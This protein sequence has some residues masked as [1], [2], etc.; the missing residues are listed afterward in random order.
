MK[1]SYRKSNNPTKKRAFTMIELIAGLLAVTILGTATAIVAQAV[2][3]RSRDQVAVSRLTSLA[4][5]VQVKYTQAQGTQTWEQVLISAAEEV[6]FTQ[7]SSGLSA[8]EGVIP[9]TFLDTCNFDGTGCME[10]QVTSLAPDEV[11][12]K[13]AVVTTGEYANQSLVGLALKSESGN[14]VMLR[15][16]VNSILDAWSTGRD[17]A[18]DCRGA[19]ALGGP[20]AEASISPTS[21]AEIGIPAQITNLAANGTGINE[22]VLSWTPSVSTDVTQYKIVR[23]GG[24]SIDPIMVSS[25]TVCTL[26]GC[27]YND[28]TAKNG[29]SYSYQVL[30]VDNTGY[31]GRSATVAVVTVPAGPTALTATGGISK[32]T[33]SWTEGSNSLITGYNIYLNG[34]TTPTTTAPG[35]VSTVILRDG[36]GGLTVTNGET[37]SVILKAYNAGGESVEATAT[38]TPLDVPAAPE[39]TSSQV[40]N[41]AVTLNWNTVSPTQS[42]PISGYRVYVNGSYLPYGKTTASATSTITGLTNGQEYA[43]QVAS[44]GT[45]G[46]GSASAAFNSTPVAPPA[47]PSNARITSITG[48]TVQVQWDSEATV[49][50]PVDNYQIY[51][52][53]EKI[54]EIGSNQLS[55]TV[56]GLTAGTGAV[57]KVRAK[58]VGPVLGA[59][60]DELTITSYNLPAVPA[61]VTV[62]Q[63]AEGELTL[64]WSA[65]TSTNSTPVSGYRIYQNGSGIP[66]TTGAS[67]KKFSSLELG[68][69]HSFQVAAYNLSGQG[70]LSAAEGSRAIGEPAS[71][72]ITFNTRTSGSVE[73]DIEVPNSTERPV[74]SVVLQR[75]LANG[76]NCQP[77]TAGLTKN[78][79]TVLGYGDGGTSYTFKLEST[80]VLNTATASTVQTI[81][82]SAIAPSN[83]TVTQ[84]AEGELTLAWN[85]VNA[86]ATG[87]ITNYQVYLNDSALLGG[88][89]TETSKTFTN[90]TL[91]TGYDLAVSARTILG[92]GASSANI[93]KTAIGVPAA[94]TLNNAVYGDGEITYS[95]AVPTSS[96]RPVDDVLL[97]RCAADGTA[98]TNHLTNLTTASTSAKVTGTG[99][100]TYTYKLKSTNVVGSTDVTD[101]RT[102][103]S[104]ASAP[105][106]VSVTRTDEKLTLDWN[107]VTDGGAGDVTDYQI[108]ISSNGGAFSTLLGGTSTGTSKEYTLGAS[109]LTLGN[110]YSFMVAARSAAGTG[111]FSAATSAVVA[112]GKPATP[113]IARKVSGGYGDGTVIFDIT[114][115]TSS[116]RPVSDVKLQ[117]CNSAGNACIDQVTTLTSSSTTVTGSGTGG[118]SYLFKLVSTNNVGLESAASVETVYNVAPAPT[119]VVVSQTGANELTLTWAAVNDASVGTVSDYQLRLSEN[120][121]AMSTLLGGTSS[122]TTKIYTSLT[123]GSTYEFQV[124]ART[125]A[126]TGTFSAATS[127]V[128][129][130]STPPTPVVS[131]SFTYGNLF[132][133]GTVSI[134]KSV[135]Q[136]VTS[137]EFFRCAP[138]GTS[139]STMGT[140]TLAQGSD[141]GSSITW[142]FRISASSAGTY[143]TYTVATNSRGTTQSAAAAAA[144]ALTVY[145]TPTA[146][147]TVTVVRT[148][149]TLTVNWTAGGSVNDTIGYRV[150]INGSAVPAKTTSFGTNTTTFTAADG[151]SNG[152]SYTFTVAAYGNAG[153]S[154]GTSGGGGQTFAA[155]PSASTVSSVNGGDNNYTISVN[156]SQ[157]AANGSPITAQ[158]VR[159]W[160]TSGGTTVPNSGTYYD[161]SPAA[162]A[163]SGTISSIG[164]STNTTFYCA[165]RT[166]N[167][168]G[169]SNWSNVTSGGAMQG[170]YS[171]YSYS[172]YSYSAYSYGAYGYSAYSYSAYSYGAYGYSAYSY[173]AYSYGAYGYSAYSY[174][175]YSYSAYGY[176]NYSAYGYG[177]YS[178]YGYGNYSAYGYGAYGAYGYGAY[179]YGAYSAGYA[180]RGQFYSY[181]Y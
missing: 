62:T 102:V 83:V 94:L 75:C 163:T 66:T 55:Y 80:N 81:Y 127:A 152:T 171:A 166:T 15:G 71:P 113:T 42:A 105:T 138:D 22:V 36:E 29:E 40:S 41:G 74:D 116:G 68:S 56:T 173:S 110:E 180:S 31:T 88:V 161:L 86:S 30:P 19:V 34:A 8:A 39:I 16:N 14:C 26:E 57:F 5:M 144:Q 38:V 160:A 117:R 9:Q 1:L 135:G 145:N 10:G 104:I 165:V 54:A 92:T 151:F 32:I 143:R 134:T 20:S 78:S 63:S 154:T 147:P 150:Y 6:R 153:E 13:A 95:I 120:G 119:N 44:Y 158:L 140:K 149:G 100:T 99:G 107:A 49:A 60:S 178:A 12:Y 28:S 33:L 130:I 69:L 114:A 25:T 162:S 168:V 121:G 124:A 157:G 118:T 51:L 106:G 131:N 103:Y 18:G 73:F 132:T 65:V 85:A 70:T 84:S 112:I 89:T 111:T 128:T 50:A 101:I 79:T 126:G 61:G 97:Q 82:D 98:C 139:C 4:R 156:W 137:V 122:T 59:F 159:C 179:G 76:T 129:A 43:F 172:A 58:N 17:M 90:L 46:E 123:N 133:D 24:V 35:T 2:I 77:H 141:N 177:N 136:P 48:T 142:N 64:D 27:T 109:Q 170:T 174:S 7:G 167:S 91:G 21:V 52:D 169:D 155:V 93:S 67:Q 125:L 72:V 3:E 87:S 11:S 108:K 45:G 115:P 181:I 175:A 37:Y 148:N 23:S 96:A 146:P 47:A 164:F 53:G 176:G